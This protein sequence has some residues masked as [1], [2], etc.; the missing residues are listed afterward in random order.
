LAAGATIS[1][2]VTVTPDAL[3]VYPLEAQVAAV[4]ATHVS[5]LHTQ[6]S[7]IA[8]DALL[9]LTRVRAY[10]TFVEYS[11]GV[12]PALSAQIANVA[13]VPLS[14]PP[15]NGGDEGGA[16]ARVQAFDAAG[17]QVYSATQP[18]QVGSTLAPIDYPLGTINTTGFLTGAYTVTVNILDQ[19]GQ[20]IP[21]A[22]GQGTLAVGQAVQASSSVA[23]SVVAPGDVTVTTFITT[24]GQ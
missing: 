24:Q 14:F 22:S 5:S 6:A 16:W 10:P 17:T 1:L 8:V 19:D 2:P 11:S 12:A 23:P 20:L 3:G 18:V 9:R 4:E 13:N 7:V 21:K 15:V